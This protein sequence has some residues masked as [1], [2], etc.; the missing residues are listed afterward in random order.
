[1]GE[2]ELDDYESTLEL[3]LV[4]EYKA[5]VGMFNYAIETDRR[6]YLANDVAIEVRSTG[7]ADAAR[8]DAARRVGVGHVPL[9]PLRAVG[10]GPDLPRREHREA[11][12]RGPAALGMAL[13]RLLARTGELDD[14]WPVTSTTTTSSSGLLDADTVIAVTSLVARSTTSPIGVWL[15]LSEDY[16]AQLAARD[17]ATLS[18]LVPL[19]TVVV[20]ETGRIEPAHADVEALLTNDE[21]ND[22]P[23]TSRPFVGAYNRPAPPRRSTCG[24]GTVQS[25]DTVRR[26]AGVSSANR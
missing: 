17:V 18:W 14:S 1:V 26:S 21:V 23:T 4:Q 3:A 13:A 11:A 19:D 24:V 16:S 22:S 10:A 9:G 25:C 5:V 7:H 6:F 8:S 20:I 2:E 12:Q 15:E